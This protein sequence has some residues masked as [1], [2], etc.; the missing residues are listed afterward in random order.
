MEA[1]ITYRDKARQSIRVAD[2]MLTMTYPLV[3]DPKLLIAVLENIQGALVHAMTSVLAYEYA[4]KRIPPYKETFENKFSMFKQHI[5]RQQALDPHIVQFIAQ[6]KELHDE[7]KN[8][9]IEFS[10]TETYVMSNERYRLN[11]LTEKDLK[12]HLQTTKTIV[13]ELLQLV[14]KNDARFK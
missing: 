1:F 3:K 6:M 11:I 5:V 8:A 13:H 7:H 9:S 2:H 4:F 14:S 10:R 12:A